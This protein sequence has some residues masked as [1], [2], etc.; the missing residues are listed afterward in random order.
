[1]QT[2]GL[3][4]FDVGFGLGGAGLGGGLVG[5]CVALPDPQCFLGGLAADVV[6]F[7]VALM[8]ARPLRQP[9]EH[10]GEQK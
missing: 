3:G 9:Y 2:G 7:V 8:L 10:G 4:R 6:G 5:E 1:L